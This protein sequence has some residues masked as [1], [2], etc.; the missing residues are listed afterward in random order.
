MNKLNSDYTRI[1]VYIYIF[2]HCIIK[3]LLEVEYVFLE[4]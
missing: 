2:M 3:V 1:Y 4:Y